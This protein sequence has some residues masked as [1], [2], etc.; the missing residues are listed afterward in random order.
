MLQ[1]ETGMPVQLILNLAEMAGGTHFQMR[2]KWFT[3]AGGILEPSL[4]VNKD[5]SAMVKWFPGAKNQWF[6]FS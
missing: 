3:A 4:K 2:W 5:V 6:R 1:S